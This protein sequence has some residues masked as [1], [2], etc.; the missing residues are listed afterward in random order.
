MGHI[1]I[2]FL[3]A[4]NIFGMPFYKIATANVYKA[5]VVFV[6]EIPTAPKHKWFNNLFQNE[7]GISPHVNKKTVQF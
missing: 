2:F 1:A 7:T 5:P 6:H 4:G 3:P